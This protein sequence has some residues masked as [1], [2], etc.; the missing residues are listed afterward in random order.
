M[1]F[2]EVKGRKNNTHTY[3]QVVCASI[4]LFTT[5]ILNTNTSAVTQFYIPNSSF[6][7]PVVQ[8]QLLYNL[9]FVQDKYIL[10]IHTHACRSLLARSRLQKSLNFAS[11]ALQRSQ[12]LFYNINQFTGFENI[13][14]I[15][16]SFL[17]PSTELLCYSECSVRVHNIIRVIFLN[18]ITWRNIQYECI[19]ITMCLIDW[20]CKCKSYT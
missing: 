19:S 13:I 17:N 8:S 5:L 14:Y 20:G 16:F 2:M 11:P 6:S 3:C 7:T 9:S 10:C 12:W 18:T 15:Y 4:Y 1:Q